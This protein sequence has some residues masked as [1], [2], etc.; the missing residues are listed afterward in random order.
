[1]LEKE[2]WPPKSSPNLNGIEISCLGS[3]ARNYFETFILSPK[4]FLNKN[5]TGED[6][7]QLSTG[8]INKV[9][10]SFSSS[11]ARVRER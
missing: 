9:V 2:Q 7:G 10:P 1:M 6:M 3:D 4:Q 11:L 8:S 5:R